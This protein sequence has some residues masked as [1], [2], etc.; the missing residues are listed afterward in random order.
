LQPTGGRTGKPP[1]G[2][3]ARGRATSG[4]ARLEEYLARN[5]PEKIGDA[6]W[7]EL[8]RELAPISES[9]L[10]KL[11]HHTGIPFGAPF[12]GVR[13]SSYELLERSL[14]EMQKVYSAAM[15]AGDQK[16]ARYARRLVIEAKD[17]ARMA[18]RSPRV[19]VE[20]RAQKA[21]MIEWMLVWLDYP[22]VFP[23]W[24]K[25]RKRASGLA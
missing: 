12:A 21:E 25:L 13:Q 16:G 10:R 17:H 7:N 20:K 4:K 24:V 3:G 1:R 22:E 19:A 14:L 23:E 5:K 11:L 18:S 8:C 2:G 9:Y 15:A 6:E